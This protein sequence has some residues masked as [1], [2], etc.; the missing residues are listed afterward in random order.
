VLNI[1][2]TIG[3]VVHEHRHHSF[4]VRDIESQSRRPSYNLGAAIGPTIESP[5][6][7]G[8]VFVARE[9][10]SSHHMGDKKESPSLAGQVPPPPA[11]FLLVEHPG[12]LPRPAHRRLVSS[13]KPKIK[14]SKQVFVVGQRA[15]SR[16]W[17]AVGF[18][19]E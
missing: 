16:C 2:A 19:A 18:D 7:W 14:H 10:A 13:L 5:R 9:H 6:L 17:D 11:R 8:S 3:L 12:L 15:G 1:D 4:G